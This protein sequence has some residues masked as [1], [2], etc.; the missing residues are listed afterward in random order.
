NL[1]SDLKV[2]NEDQAAVTINAQIAGSINLSVNGKSLST[3]VAGPNMVFNASSY[4][5]AED[6][7]GTSGFDFGLQTANGSS[8]MTLTSPSDLAAFIGKGKLSLSEVA[9]STSSA[10]GSGNLVTKAVS[11]AG[12]QVTVIYTYTPSTDLVAGQYKIILINNPPGYQ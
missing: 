5:G 12:S 10:S 7:A 11:Q 1:N 2:E 8:S 6:F 9:T 3:S 4:D